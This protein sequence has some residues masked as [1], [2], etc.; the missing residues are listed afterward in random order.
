MNKSINSSIIIKSLFYA[1]IVVIILLGWL[2]NKVGL[3]LSTGYI[4]MGIALF[5]VLLFSITKLIDNPKKS[6]KSLLGLV[7]IV[8]VFLIAYFTASEESLSKIEVTE[9]YIKFVGGSL[10]LLYFIGGASVLAIIASEIH[11]LFK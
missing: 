7:A 9:G 4:L 1:A 5:A 10:T 11:S 2:G 8:L 6:L 3:I